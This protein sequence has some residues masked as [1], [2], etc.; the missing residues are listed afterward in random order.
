MT[1]IVQLTEADQKKS[2]QIHALIQQ[3]DQAKSCSLAQLQAVVTSSTTELW[4]AREGAE[5]IGMA[6]LVFVTRL[7]GVT[8]R[9]EDVVV[10]QDQRGKGLGRALIEK[11][12][13]RAKARGAYSLS[14]TS[15]TVR[16]VANKLYQK[17][18]FEKK[19]TNSYRMQL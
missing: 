4:V 1:E 19:E 6:T 15:R 2:E 14:L 12:I 13:E 11:L 17:V 8:A 3:L 9:V 5:L 18:G 10:D 7:S 16:E